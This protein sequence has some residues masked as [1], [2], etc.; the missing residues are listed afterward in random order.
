MMDPY[1]YGNMGWG[2][3]V[4]MGLVI[5]MWTALVVVLAVVAA[6]AYLPA[7]GR[8]ETPQPRTEPSYESRLLE[9]E[10]HV[11]HLREQSHLTHRDGAGSR[12]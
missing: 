9:L 12:H 3:W 10:G 6:R 4:G 7:I 8:R 11:A 2:S 5:L 1:G